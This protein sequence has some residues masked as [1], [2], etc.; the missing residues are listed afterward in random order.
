MVCG[1]FDAVYAGNRDEQWPIFRD[2]FELFL[3][4]IIL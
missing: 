1:I 2:G 3:D 4:I